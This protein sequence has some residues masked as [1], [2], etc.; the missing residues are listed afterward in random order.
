MNKRICFWI[1]LFVGVM[2]TGYWWYFHEN[3]SQTAS[4]ICRE[5]ESYVPEKHKEFIKRQFKENW[6]WLISSPEYDVDHMLDTHSPNNYE[7]Q[8]YGKM[9]ILVICQEGEPVGFGSYY[10]RTAVQGE[11]LFIEVDKQF[12][13]KGIAQKLVGC[14]EE[15]LKLAG[16]KTVK[17]CTRVENEIARRL[18]QR[19]GYQETCQNRG[20]VYFRK[21]L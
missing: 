12:R 4:P 18:Y 11:I 1:A 6:Y 3:F 7:P 19:L 14:I 2:G 16:A 15:K 21:A 13:G 9:N 8:Y 5:T 20:F 17:L 10:M